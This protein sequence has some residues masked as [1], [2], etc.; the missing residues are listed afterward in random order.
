MHGWEMQ[1]RC[2]S[3]QSIDKVSESVQGYIIHLAVEVLE[4]GVGFE[5]VGK[6]TCTL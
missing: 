6:S 3:V 5:H 2:I 4:G 1:Q